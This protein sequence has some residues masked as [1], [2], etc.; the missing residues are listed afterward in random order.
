MTSTSKVIFLFLA[1]SMGE[2]LERDTRGLES[3]GFKA[4]IEIGHL[5]SNFGVDNIENNVHGFVTLVGK[6]LVI[7]YFLLLASFMAHLV[8]FFFTLTAM[9][10]KIRSSIQMPVSDDASDFAYE[11]NEH[12]YFPAK[13][14]AVTLTPETY[15]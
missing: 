9:R 14:S 5:I 10:K 1:F 15:V 13:I 8:T 2:E 3:Q 7:F 6:N 11:T 4:L 12:E